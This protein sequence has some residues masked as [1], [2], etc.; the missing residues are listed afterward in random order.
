[1]K[2]NRVFV[3]TCA[4]LLLCK[5]RLLDFE[6]SFFA[7]ND[8]S[9]VATVSGYNIT[10]TAVASSQAAT[11]PSPMAQLSHR[12]QTSIAAVPAISSATLPPKSVQVCYTARQSDNDFFFLSQSVTA[13]FF[14][15]VC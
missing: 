6:D 7:G 13:M 2:I 10:G 9:K 12:L 3:V 11:A 15:S 8:V 5:E 14:K 1:M 4:T